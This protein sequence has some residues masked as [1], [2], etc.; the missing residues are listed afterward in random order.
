MPFRNLHPERFDLDTM[1]AMQGVYDSICKKLK[2][3]PTDPRTGKLAA[4]IANLAASGER[5][6]LLKRAMQITEGSA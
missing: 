3:E 5:E 4:T 6:N 1:K 2:I